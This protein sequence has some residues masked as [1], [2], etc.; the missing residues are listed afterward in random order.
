[1]RKVLLMMIITVCALTNSYAQKVPAGMKYQAVARNSSG[2]VLANRSITLRIDLKSDASKGNAVYYSEEHT[3]TTNQLGLFDLVVGEGQNITGVFNDI[4]WSTENI[5][6]AVSMK[7]KSA[8]FSAVTESKLLAVPY[9]FYAASA[10]EVAGKIL[11]NGST[12]LT[13]RGETSKCPCKGG[14]SQVKV[15]YLGPTNVTIKVYRKKE[16]TELLT[17][18]NNVTNGQ[19]LTVNATNFPDGKLK[20]NTYFQVVS[21]G[22]AVTEIPTECEETKEPWEMS[23]GE[24][25]GNFSVL[26]HLDRETGA[27]CTVCDLKKEWHVGGNGLMDLCNWLGT[28]SNTDL[29]LI[30]NNIERLKIKKEG[31]IEIKRSLSI[32]ANLTVD[33]AVLLNRLGGATLNH[34][35]FTVDGATDLNTSLNVDGPTDLQSR[36]NVNNASPTRLT[37]TL[38]VDGVT[39]LNAALNVNNVSPTL[40]TGTLRVNKPALFKDSVFLDDA[41]HQSNSTTTGALVVAGGLGVGGNFNV[42][43]KSAFGGPV[44]FAAAV[45]ISDLTQSTNTSTGALTV[46]GGVGIG[47][48]L[49]VG[50]GG[51][52]Q[53]TL[54]VVGLTS[55]TNTTQSTS[56]LNGALVVAGGAGFAKNLNIGGTLISAG[57]AT[58]NNTLTINGSAGYVA[59]FNNATS[60][61]GIAIKIN[62]THPDKNNVYIDFQDNAGTSIGRIKGQQ[63]SELTSTWAYKWD[64]ATKLYDVVNGAVAVGIATVNL[65]EVIDDQIADDASANVCAGLGVVACPPIPSLIIGSVIKVAIAVIEEASVI[66]DVAIAAVNLNDFEN[67]QN[68]GD[69]LVFES[70]A[71]DYAE[72]LMKQQTTEKFFPGDI[73]GVKGGKISKNIEGAEKIMVISHAPI[74]LG[75]APSGGGE[76][77][78]EKVA[79]MGQVPV[80]VFGRVN[81]GDYIIP[82]GLNNGVGIAVAQEKINPADVKNIVGIAWSASDKDVALNNIN[83]AIGLNVND[84][85]K[86]IEAQQNEIADLKG[87]IAQTNAQLE[88]LVPGFKAPANANATAYVKSTTIGAKNTL[89]PIDNNAAAL[90]SV[91]FP[92]KMG[93]NEIQYVNVTKS[94]FA[95]AFSIA[96]DRMKVNGAMNPKYDVFW[97]KYNSDPTYRDDILNKLM[98][99]YKQQLDAH[100]SLD[101]K[102]NK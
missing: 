47:K 81:L 88:K 72:Y 99:R 74:V 51:L 71:A 90:Q 17:T 36:L 97:K 73:V 11:T 21:P 34:G 87:Q 62:K 83:V 4:P 98:V 85:Q 9:A 55:L 46:G 39:D 66:A 96:E 38:R 82:N 25:F 93:Q 2:E 18:F 29:I 16:L 100:K 33:S 50:E 13:G 6:M 5:W 42:G 44:S 89:R 26:S 45:T 68:T 69:G 80:K 95:S 35:N 48:R 65:A 15:L 31:D 8:D 41:G 59:Q 64:H 28:K 1:M 49:N 92:V 12:T 70:G 52:F 27:E 94:D 32:G 23:L 86:L 58:I 22:I 63:Y 79:F 75:N 91:P 20:E 3:V 19:I 102:V 84:N 30:T 56:T 7:D 101:A 77:N 40:L 60:S 37:G 67:N 76:A 24:T 10:G 43:G 57:A 53:S 61:N 14:L 78:Y 54:G